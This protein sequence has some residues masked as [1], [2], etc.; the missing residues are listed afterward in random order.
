MAAFWWAIRDGLLRALIAR[1]MTIDLTCKNATRICIRIRHSTSVTHLRLECR[2]D[3]F[4]AS[5]IS[6]DNKQSLCFRL[7]IAFWSAAEVVAPE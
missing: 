6:R 4:K 5:A 7:E 2:N 3:F 1:G